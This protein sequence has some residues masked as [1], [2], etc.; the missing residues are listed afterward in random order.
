VVAD[1]LRGGGDVV[2]VEGQPER[3]SAVAGGAERHP[4]PGLGRVGVLG[5]VGGDQSGHIDQVGFGGRL[6]RPFVRFHAAP[7]GR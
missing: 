4:L 5:V 7:P 1:R 6:A 2:L 3:R